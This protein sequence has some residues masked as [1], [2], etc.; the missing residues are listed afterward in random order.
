MGIPEGFPSWQLKEEVALKPQEVDGADRLLSK[1]TVKFDSGWTNCCQQEQ[2]SLIQ[3]WFFTK[4]DGATGAATA[5][6]PE[7]VG[8][9]LKL[10]TGDA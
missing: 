2:E 7:E 5:D 9:D 6:V 10:P 4:P 8:P 1:G 3:A